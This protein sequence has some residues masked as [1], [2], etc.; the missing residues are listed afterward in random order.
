MGRP[1]T[2]MVKQ[3]VRGHQIQQRSPP[4]RKRKKFNSKIKSQVNTA[5]VISV[6]KLKLILSHTYIILN[7]L[8]FKI[9]QILQDYGKF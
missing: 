6:T 8:I 2:K 7:L 4:P 5:K 9:Y 3:L 1:S